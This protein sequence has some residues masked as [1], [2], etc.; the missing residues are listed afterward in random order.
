MADWHLLGRPLT[1]AIRQAL[2]VSLDRDV[3]WVESCRDFEGELLLA[4]LRGRVGELTPA[5]WAQ[6]RERA[7]HVWQVLARA[8]PWVLR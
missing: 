2:D 4:N 6:L 1:H 7:L 5:D 3:A 8:R